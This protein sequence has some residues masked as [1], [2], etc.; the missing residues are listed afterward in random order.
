MTNQVLKVAIATLLLVV[1]AACASAPSTVPGKTAASPLLQRDILQ[2][3]LA[4][5]SDKDCNQRKLVNTEVVVPPTSANNFT[6]VERWTL[7]RCGKPTF[8]RVTMSPSPRGGTDFRVG[9]ETTMQSP[10][11]PGSAMTPLMSAAMSGRID[12]AK[13]LLDGGA[14]VNEKD[15][16]SGD[17]PI[18][19]ASLN[20]RS[21]MVLFLLKQG[22]DARAIN[23][24]GETALTYVGTRCLSPDAAKALIA[25][26]ANA[27]E[28]INKALLNAATGPHDPVSCLNL[29]KFFIESGADLNYQD[30]Y[31]NTPLILAST[32]GHSE[33]VRFLLSKGANTSL[34]N[35]DGKTALDEAQNREVRQILTDAKRGQQ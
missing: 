8:Y 27:K 18:I 22:A 24:H 29:V 34:K 13:T 31:D 2:L 16:R 7:D 10:S 32:W 23:N 19:R 6:S 21:E 14:N 28:E 33:V 3:I 26:A 35:K 15:S 1:L 4:L 11:R 20:G 9:P 5:D 12:A 17:T 25:S 30:S